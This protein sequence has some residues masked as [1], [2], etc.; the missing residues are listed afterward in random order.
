MKNRLKELRA[1]RGW[2][3]ADLAEHLDVARNVGLGDIT[4][5]TQVG[6]GGGAG[7]GAVGQ[8]AMAI[9]TGQCNVA[10]AWRARK[11]FTSLIRCTARERWSAENSC[12]R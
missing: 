5:F 4:F 1:E 2:S 7:C 8:A 11:R 12:S 9:A 3:Q 10:V 6:Y